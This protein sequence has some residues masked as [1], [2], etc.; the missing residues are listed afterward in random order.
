MR[1]SNHSIGST[2]R[3]RCDEQMCMFVFDEGGGVFEANSL[4]LH[5][6]PIDNLVTVIWP[7]KLSSKK[8]FRISY[9]IIRTYVWVEFELS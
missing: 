6:S 8:S 9:D 7:F 5:S 2:R 3:V 1:N 4:A